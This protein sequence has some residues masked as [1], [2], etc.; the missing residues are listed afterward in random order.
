M[1]TRY[2]HDQIGRAV[3]IG[4]ALCLI[5]SAV[6]ASIAGMS[7]ATAAP[8]TSLVVVA[9]LF[10]RLRIS[11]DAKQLRWSFGIGLIRYSEPIAAIARIELTR[12]RWYEGQGIQR[13]RRG[14][15]YNVH[16]GDAVIVHRRDG[17]R[18]MLGSDDARAL[19]RAIEAVMPAP[20]EP[21]GSAA[22]R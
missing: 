19:M 13:T 20:A 7:I 17:S 16:C 5:G 10:W 9:V 2:E 3:L 8:A 6:A 15:L 4:L 12:T 11:V 1:S 14:R 21:A 18:F 22:G